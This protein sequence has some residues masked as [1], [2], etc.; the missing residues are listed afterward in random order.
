MSVKSAFDTIIKQLENLKENAT[1][2]DRE[3][4][5]LKASYKRVLAENE[6]LKLEIE[7]LK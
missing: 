1:E 3:I 6:H 5:E 4:I 2:K 7:Q